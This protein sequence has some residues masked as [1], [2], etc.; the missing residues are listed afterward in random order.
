MNR[1][2]IF[3]KSQVNYV[4]LIIR[5]KR[6]ERE[7]SRTVMIKLERFVF[8]GINFGF[9]GCFHKLVK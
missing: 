2:N 5:T 8:S 3:L 6:A 1:I 7:Q 9:I 4:F